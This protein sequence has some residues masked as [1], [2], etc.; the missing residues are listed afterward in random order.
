MSLR[1]LCVRKEEQNTL[2]IVVEF[3]GTI[4]NINIGK[5]SNIGNR[6]KQLLRVHDKVVCM[7]MCG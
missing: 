5:W 3:N 2:E 1:V 6:H 7:V 4:D